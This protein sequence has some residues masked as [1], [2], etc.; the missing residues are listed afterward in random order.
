MKTLPILF[1]TTIFFISCNESENKNAQTK[2]LV[3]TGDQPGLAIGLD[4]QI[5]VVFGNEESIY[6]ASST[7]EG[8]SFSQPSLVGELKGLFLGY[9]SGPRIAITK[10]YTVVTAMNKEGNYFAW[11]KSN[12]EE[13]W[14]KPVRVNDVDRSA[15][16]VL[17]DLAATPDGKFFAVWI[18]TRVLEDEKNVEH[19]N[20]G[21]EQKSISIEPRTEEELDKVT[22]KGITVREL[23]RQNSDVPANTRLAFF[24]DGDENIYWVFL[25]GQGDVVKAEN[26]DL[27]K[28]FKERN[29]GRVKPK[30]KIYLSS[31]EDG[32]KNWSI[33][34]LIYR[35]PEG[36]VC[37]CCKPSITSDING[38]LTVM[39][40]N[41]IGGSR[42]L[43]YTRSTDGGISFSA[44]K[45][46]GTGTWKINGCPMDGGGLA[47]NNDGELKTIWQR[48]GEIFIA[49]SSDDEHMIGE[50]RSPSI[51]VKDDQTFIVFTSGED[52]MQLNS[53][54]SQPIKI[55]TGSSPKVIALADGAIQFWVSEGGIRYRKI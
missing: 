20:H 3:S 26:L 14:L 34:Q 43:H 52:I 44:P 22:P 11:S 4:D 30:G 17:G 48:K 21:N 46:L 38:V 24:G 16:E 27:Y 12:A 7:D 51:S 40:R 54:D 41:N 25:D 8:E 36:S 37:E 53:K 2:L 9:S 45:K 18:D 6:I 32:G 5:F 23:Y 49:N 1:L 28:K 50:G 33:S 42:D 35:S 47:V 15:T 13:N 31:S 19:A 55:G 29:K 39:F 10:D